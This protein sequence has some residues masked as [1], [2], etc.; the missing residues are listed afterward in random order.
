MLF[1]P[2]GGLPM[3]L[4]LSH[5]SHLEKRSTSSRDPGACEKACF[6]S[7][8]TSILSM[9]FMVCLFRLAWQ[10]IPLPKA[11]KH[12]QNHRQYL[13]TPNKSL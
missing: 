7:A 11:E 12:A 9:K 13:I 8:S 1:V 5:Q 4:V 6:C 2:R 3:V 10:L